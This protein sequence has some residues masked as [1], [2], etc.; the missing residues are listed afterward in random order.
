MIALVSVLATFTAFAQNIEGNPAAPQIPSTVSVTARGTGTVIGKVVDIN[1][2][3][4]KTGNIAIVPCKYP[5]DPVAAGATRPKPPL[6]I[7]RGT[8]ADDG[9]FEIENVPI[10]GPFHIAVHVPPKDLPPGQSGSSPRHSKNFEVKAN[11][12]VDAGTITVKFR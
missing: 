6:Q 1:N 10:G 4:L 5:P 3:P 11:E 8:S 2:K 12:T 9:T 7:G